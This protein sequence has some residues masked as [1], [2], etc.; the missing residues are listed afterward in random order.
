MVV[1]GPTLPKIGLKVDF[2]MLGAVEKEEL[3][4]APLAMTEI[5]EYEESL[6]YT[7]PQTGPNAE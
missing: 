6:L 5:L 2:K 7:D 3:E 1:S 4:D